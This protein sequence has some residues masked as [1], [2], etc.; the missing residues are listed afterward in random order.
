MSRNETE[1]YHS[2]VT[3]RIN[4]FMLGETHWRNTIDAYSQDGDE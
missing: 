2:A 1:C 3:Y 4:R